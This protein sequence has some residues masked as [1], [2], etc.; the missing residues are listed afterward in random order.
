MRH[1]VEERLQR[2]LAIMATLATRG[3]V[4]IGELCERYR[5]TEHQLR[6]DLSLAQFLGV[7]PYVEIAPEVYLDD[8]GTVMMRVPEM[9]R[10][11]PTLT[12]PEA[13]AVLATG[14]A[15]LEI[16]PGLDA[17]RS[18]MDELATALDLEGALDVSLEHPE[19]LDVVRRAVGE[20]RRLRVEYWSAWRDEL[21]ERTIEPLHLLF[22]NGWWYLQAGDDRSGG[23]RIFRVDRIV[24]CTD[25]GEG[26]GPPPF[27]PIT[28]VFEPPPFAVRATVRFPRSAEWV[29]EY[30]DMDVLD[31]GGH[32][33]GDG[34]TAVVTS[35]GE[36]WLGRL[37][38]RTG[39]QVLE[40]DQLRDLRARTAEKVLA[41][42]G[43]GLTP[44]RR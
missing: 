4:P 20:R 22:S 24:S 9:F 36:T 3:P 6:K 8:D 13:F 14:R 27:E 33:E 44:I 5:V 35:V 15:A 12:R 30:V 16:D 19:H 40:P 1:P 23:V 25:T 7:P 21:T 34:F 37:L 10:R 38:L 28:E 41:R 32:D 11:Q 42:Y 29:T 2:L 17:L 18:A 39:G 43:G 26:F 31:P